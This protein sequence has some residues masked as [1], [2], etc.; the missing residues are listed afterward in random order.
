[1][2]KPIKKPLARSLQGASFLAPNTSIPHFDL[3]SPQ[4]ALE[5]TRVLRPIAANRVTRQQDRSR[6]GR[7]SGS[8]WSSEIVRVS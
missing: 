5:N 2:F 8:Q 4:L 6:L 7:P 3:I 1:M